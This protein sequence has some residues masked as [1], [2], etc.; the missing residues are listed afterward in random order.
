MNLKIDSSKEEVLHFL[1]NKFN[2]NEKALS[3]IS[4][5]EINGEALSLLSKKEYKFLEIKISDRNKIMSIIE[6]DILKL[7][8][9][10]KQNNTYKYIYEQ[11][12]NNL[13][14]SLDNFISKSK[15]GEKVRFIKYLLIRDPPPEK[16]KID[17][18]SKYLK[19]VFK[20]EEYV[21]LI[22]KSLEDLLKYNP[23]E[24]EE[25]CLDWEFSNNDFLKIKI[26]VELMKQNKNKFKN[27]KDTMI[28]K[29][30]LAGQNE[31]NKISLKNRKEQNNKIN[32]NNEVPL[33]LLGLGLISP[34]NSI[35]DKYVIYLVITVHQ[36]ETSEGETTKGV[37][38]PIEEFEK[39]C[40]D[41]E[42]NFQNECS[43]IDYNKANKIKLSTFMIWGSKESL[44]QFF[45]DNKIKEAF[46][47]FSKNNEK[48]KRAGIYLCINMN[49]KIGY[50]IIWPG[51][52]EYQYSKI[53]EPN[54]NILLT[55][56]RYGFSLSSNSIICLT[57]NE[58]DTF[59][60]NGAK[61]FEEE[62]TFGYGIERRKIVI[63][64]INE[65]I[66]NL[67][68]KFVVKGLDEIL[69][70][71]KIINGKINQNNILLFEEKEETLNSQNK[72][73]DISDFIKLYSNYDLHFEN[74]FNIDY[75]NFY[76]LIKNNPC[77]LSKKKR[78]K[79]YIIFKI[80]FTRY[81]RRKI[82]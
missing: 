6:K 41:F 62:W 59:N 14:D 54:D 34:S 16:G 61:I 36:Y 8:D 42:I 81:F 56:I 21:E 51:N 13:W 24:F 12:L 65:K 55:L 2:L 74:D 29:D 44:F 67:S 50:L 32:R 76:R 10:I 82:E 73:T 66:F 7:N 4:N 38:N 58:I 49:T 60:F 28:S 9:N 53:D 70:N 43:F 63:N 69:N 26:I 39:I 25:Q 37:I 11:D 20:K 19:K 5:E 75:D 48:K 27:L 30:I 71:K 18:L 45:K 68:E 79:K 64:E 72:K 52:L 22:I 40:Q 35:E 46:D 80:I 17:D 3:K 23:D 33:N 1:K 77:Y 31:K 47:Y 78:R 15:L 57:K